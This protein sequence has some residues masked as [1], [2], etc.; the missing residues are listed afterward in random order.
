MV[1]D[2]CPSGMKCWVQFLTET[3]KGGKKEGETG[4]SLIWYIIPHRNNTHI[5][6]DEYLLHR[7]AAPSEPDE[8]GV[9]GG[10][11]L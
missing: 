5:Q 9:W 7:L 1:V 4:D 2:A 6:R 3:E 10:A 8:P 11:E